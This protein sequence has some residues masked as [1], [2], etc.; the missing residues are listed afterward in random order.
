MCKYFK[1]LHE[2][3]ILG[4]VLAVP[5]AYLYRLIDIFGR[6]FST[7]LMHC[8]ER[9]VQNGEYRYINIGMAVYNFRKIRILFK[10]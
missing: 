9:R 6:N 5:F 10:R 1:G 8:V 7:K 2:A 3:A 4:L